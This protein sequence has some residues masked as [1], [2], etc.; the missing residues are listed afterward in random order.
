MKNKLVSMP[1]LL[2]ISEVAA[3]MGISKLSVYRRISGGDLR[4][5]RISSKA[6][7]VLELDLQ[8]YLD[9]VGPELTVKETAAVL[10]LSPSTIYEL[11]EEK[12]LAATRRSPKQIRIL[13]GDLQDYIKR[14]PIV[15]NVPANLFRHRE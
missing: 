4:A 9:P 14:Q 5:I 2:T 10:K 13:R 6:L 1:V 8:A 7:R 3:R 11:I 12:K 15:T